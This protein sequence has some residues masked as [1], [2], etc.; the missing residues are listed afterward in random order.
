VS[1]AYRVWI[2]PEHAGAPVVPDGGPRDIPL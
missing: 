2:L 1:I